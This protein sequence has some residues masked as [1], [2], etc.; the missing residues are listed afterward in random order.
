[1]LSV[2][3]VNLEKFFSVASF[4][5]DRLG[6]IKVLLEMGE[7]LEVF[8]VQVDDFAD[9]IVGLQPNEVT[10]GQLLIRLNF[11]EESFSVD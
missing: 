4:L 2:Y 10:D 7:V 9:L 1:M 3:K 8:L 5:Q 11:I 6:P